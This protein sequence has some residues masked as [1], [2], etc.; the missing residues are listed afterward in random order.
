MKTTTKIGAALALAL[1][2][3]APA[4][5]SALDGGVTGGWNTGLGVDASA[6]FEHFTRDLPLS[7]R[8]TLGWHASDAGDPYAARRIF[9]N[10]NTNGDPTKSADSWLLRF[11][12]MFPAFHLGGQ[13]V[14]VFAGPRH[15]IYNAHYDFVGGNEV[16][17]IGSDPWGLGVGAESRFAMGPT[18]TFLMQ[19]GF[20]W[21]GKTTIEGHDTA[22][23][24][25]GDN[26]NPRN[27]YTWSDAD[28]AIGQPRWEVVAMMGIRFRL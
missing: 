23:L 12:L 11:D 1:A 14:D 13:Q 21:Y 17:D 3:A 25:S 7:A 4:T 16:F 27:D 24:P 26:V 10:D 8:F 6:T 5:A 20:D 19:A 9:I 28:R 15:A 2:L 18:T 22:Y